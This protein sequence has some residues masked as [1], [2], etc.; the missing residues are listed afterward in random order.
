MI[1]QAGGTWNRR[2]ESYSPQQSERHRVTLVGSQEDAAMQLAAWHLDFETDA[3]DRKSLFICVDKRRGGKTV[4][5]GIAVGTFAIRYPYTHLGPT[6]C[7]LVVPT[8]SQQRE[9]HETL[10][11]LFPA[12]WFLDGRIVYHKSENYY[13]LANGA[14]IWIKSA[15][16]DEG[17]KLGR[18]SAVAANEA[19]QLTSRAVLNA[20]GSN[21]DN[22]GITFLALNPPDSVKGLWAEDLHDA[23]QEVDDTGRPVLGFAGEVAFPSEKN[24]MI[25]QQG[26]SRFRA[27]ASVIDKKQAQ[28]D[29]LGFWISIRD[30][31]Y[32]H[33]KRDA[34]R[35]EP[36]GWQDLTAEVN[37]LT[38]RVTG[39]CAFG[40]GMDYQRR[41]WCAWIEAKVYQ[42]PAGAWVPAGSYVYVVRAEICN[43]IQLPGG[44]WTEDA[45]CSKVDEYLKAKGRTPRHYLLIGDATGHNQGASAA[46]RG[47][48]SDPRTWSWARAQAW[49]WEPHAAIE[50]RKLERHGSYEAATVKVSH[51]NPKVAERLDLMNRVL[52]ENRL[53]ITPDCPET[54]ESFRRCETYSDTRKPK[55][56]GAHLTDAVGY[57]VYTWEKALIEA[58]AIAPPVQVDGRKLRG[59]VAAQSSVER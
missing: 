18:F 53:V 25:D 14:E 56:K 6:I 3:P 47:K 19:Q 32:P 31:A 10:R 2:L 22:G 38:G 34:V 7:A 28:R 1:F 13:S 4:F 57:L 48:E 30:R 37:G 44:W 23:L 59:L 35:N 49:G 46:Q 58:G 39:A 42:A 8:F 12:E 17:L 27:L 21:I 50:N 43:D 45:L 26:L 11:I 24:E 54:A 36:V 40:A 41:P 55:G 51:L 29:G 33:Y 9:I 16:G 20:L 5:I 15:D 52:S